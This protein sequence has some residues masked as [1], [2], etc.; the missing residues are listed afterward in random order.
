MN[1]EKK[2]KKKRNEIKKK[3]KK[4]KKN[5]NNGLKIGCSLAF[6]KNDS[7]GL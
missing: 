1:L 4:K 7:H 6:K 3:K 2:K 5:I